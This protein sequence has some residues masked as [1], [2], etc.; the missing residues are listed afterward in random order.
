MDQGVSLSRECVGSANSVN[1]MLELVLASVLLNDERSR[2]IAAA[3]EQQS[4][5]TEGNEKNSVKI[6]ANGRFNPEDYFQC[7]Q[8]HSQI[9]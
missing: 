9:N 6:A 7:K 5:V 8:Y 1:Q 2:E 3:V 4:E